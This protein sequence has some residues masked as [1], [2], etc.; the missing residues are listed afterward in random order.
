[1]LK[2]KSRGLHFGTELGAKMAPEALLEP[3]GRQG[4]P[5]PPL[6][7]S[8]G[9]SWRLLGLLGPS[10]ALPGRLREVIFGAFFGGRRRD[11]DIFFLCVCVCMCVFSFVF[12]PF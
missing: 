1:M 10:W 11:P 2:M 5:R 12:F 7:G 9:G 6:S 3:L 4:G 8:L